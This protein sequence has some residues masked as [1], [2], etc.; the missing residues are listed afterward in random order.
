MLLATHFGLLS[1]RAFPLTQE[2]SMCRNVSRCKAKVLAQ[3]HCQIAQLNMSAHGLFTTYVCSCGDP[4]VQT[5]TH[6]VGQQKGGFSAEGGAEVGGG[7][8]KTRREPQST[9]LV[10]RPTIPILDAFITRN[11]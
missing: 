4:C 8:R 10:L 3:I 11:I 9:L 7:R 1:A 6:C 5:S 2:E